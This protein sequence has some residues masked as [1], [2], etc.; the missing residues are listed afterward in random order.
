MTQRVDLT[1]VAFKRDPMPTFARLREAGPI[2]RVK[3][4]MVGRCWITTTYEAADRVLRDKEHFCTD[5][6]NAGLKSRT[7]MLGVMKWFLPKL[8][9][10]LMQNMLT[11][12]EPDHRRLRSLVE[13]AFVRSSVEEMR[14][15]IQRIVDG[16]LDLMEQAADA[17][18]TVDFQNTFA[19]R[20]PLAVICEI[21]RTARGRSRQV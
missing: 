10:T 12:D 6:L 18:G 14:P 20:V 15:G 5:A 9:K 7:A 21:D 8:F 1:S 11:M 16:E 17:N 19:R 2:L 4:P 13:S 3:L